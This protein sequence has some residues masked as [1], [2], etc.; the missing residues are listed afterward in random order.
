MKTHFISLLILL[1]ASFA[2]LAN[3]GKAPD[4]ASRS[5]HFYVTYRLNPDGSHV[6]T[7][8]TAVTVLKQRAIEN[9]KETSITYSTSIQKVNVLSAYTQKPDGR[10][11]DVPKT[12][13]QVSLNRGK[14]K[15]A[16][17]F[18]DMTT[19]SVVFPEVAVDDTLFLSYRIT[20]D[21]PM[22]PG[23]FSVRGLFPETYEYDDVRIVVDAPASLWS[24]Y[25]ARQME[26]KVKEANGRR[27]IRWTL[28]NR[29]PIKSERENYSVYELDRHP[30]YAFSTFRSYREIA[31]AY[32]ARALPK[33]AVT[34]RIKNLAARIVGDETGPRA[35]ARALYDWVATKIT[36]AGNCIGVGAVVPHDLGFI[37]DNRM[38]D[39]KD[40]AT[41]LQALLAARG[42]H[43]TQALINAGS[44]Y[45]LPKVPVVSTVNHVINYIPAWRMFLDSTASTVPFGM[46][47]FASADKPVLL[48]A[49]F[50]PGMRTPPVPVGSNRQHMKSDI[51]ISKDGSAKGSIEVSLNGMFAASTRAGLRHL[52][53]DTEEKLVKNVLRGRGY[54]GDGTFQ[55]D[56]PGPLL[57]T[58]QYKVNLHLKEFLQMPGAG[59]FRISPLF[60]SEAPV[61]RFLGQ[62][63]QPVE[64]VDVSC[65]SAYSAEEY[66]YIF[67][68]G[69]K[70][71]SIPKDTEL[72]NDFLSYRATYRVDG[73]TLNVKR[74]INDKTP[75]DVCSPALQRAYK[76]FAR[77]AIRDTKAQV[78]Y[79]TAE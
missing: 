79:Q 46:L 41:L 65:A 15:N 2:A 26:Q 77:K 35:Q 67:P 48:V 36:Y 21:T 50:T 71:L 14:D 38:G 16:P 64:N 42:I 27:V 30:G 57:D 53:K 70:F 72:S 23:K 3:D 54:T 59:A 19:L 20:Q 24:Q 45:T 22:F 7:H 78:L 11:I 6:E 1:F 68:A 8:D 69:A 61:A 32:G 28:H 76:K 18:S 12:N 17:V 39:C 44:N 9:L 5:D 4:L 49:G 56:D 43:A 29:H 34:E 51:R 58:Y 62:A 63:F 47:P 60:Y 37:L 10:R 75:G 74:I 25:Q 73:H 13:F 66:T 40:H 52:S 31:E 33:A 55:K